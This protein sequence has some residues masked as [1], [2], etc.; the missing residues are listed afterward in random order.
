M[1]WGYQG[2]ISGSSD[3]QA[4]HISLA[5][6]LPTYFLLII[7]DN[8][9]GLP[10]LSAGLLVSVT[11]SSDSLELHEGGG[12]IVSLEG[13]ASTSEVGTWALIVMKL[14]RRK[15]TFPCCVSGGDSKW[16]FST[17]DPRNH[18]LRR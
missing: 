11:G 7:R 8:G 15:S 3:R 17:L 2:Y 6:D 18:L 10:S 13:S 14:W 16:T 9:V 4:G 1:A 12:G 5:P